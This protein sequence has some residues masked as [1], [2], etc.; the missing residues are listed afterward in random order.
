MRVSDDVKETWK[1]TFDSTLTVSTS[2]PVPAEKLAVESL[3]A[4]VNSMFDQQFNTRMF[5][6]DNL[7]H[8]HDGNSPWADVLHVCV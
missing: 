6:I 7:V 8:F 3:S 5:L 4:L 2:F 1:F